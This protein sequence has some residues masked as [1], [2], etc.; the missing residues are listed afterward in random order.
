VTQFLHY[1]LV[2]IAGA[3]CGGLGFVVYMFVTILTWEPHT[4]ES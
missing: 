2:F 4:D 1:A 3:L